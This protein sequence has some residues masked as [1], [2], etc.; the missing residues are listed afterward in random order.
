VLG[1]H[2][3]AKKLSVIASAVRR[4]RKNGSCSGWGC[5]GGLVLNAVWAF[6][7]EGFQVGPNAVFLQGRDKS[8]GRVS[9]ESRWV[10]G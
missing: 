10:M 2:C 4:W 3:L 8:L 9:R 1:Q 7:V 5:F 6:V